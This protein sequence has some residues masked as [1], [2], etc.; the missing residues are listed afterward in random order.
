V[1]NIYVDLIQFNCCQITINKI[2]SKKGAL[3]KS[4]KGYN[5]FMFVF[6]LKIVGKFIGFYKDRVMDKACISMRGAEKAISS[7][8]SDG[9][10]WLPF[11]AIWC[12]KR[13]CIWQV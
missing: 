6:T 9:I 13:V 1:C 7:N 10:N 8:F 4:A 2:T 5:T 11:V 3:K 12:I